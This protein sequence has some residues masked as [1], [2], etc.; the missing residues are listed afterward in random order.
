LPVTFLGGRSLAPDVSGRNPVQYHNQIDRGVCLLLTL[1]LERSGAG[2]PTASS[3]ST[4]SNLENLYGNGPVR[5]PL[6]TGSRSAI[7]TRREMDRLHRARQ[8]RRKVEAFP[9]PAAHLQIST[10]GGDSPGGATERQR[11]LG[12]CTQ[13]R[14]LSVRR[15]PRWPLPDQLLSLQPFSPLTAVTGWNRSS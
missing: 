13:P 4:G 1:L 2:C 9:G 7:L 6:S 15:R 12:D 10:A 11:R 5:Y 14:R 8:S 3:L